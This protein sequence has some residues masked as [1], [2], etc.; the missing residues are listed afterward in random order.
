MTFTRPLGMIFPWAV[1]TISICPKQAHMMAM[2]KNAMID[3]VRILPMGDGGVSRISRAAGR[4]SRSMLTMFR[5]P[6]FPPVIPRLPDL[7]QAGK[8]TGS[9]FFIL[10]ACLVV[11]GLPFF[12]EPELLVSHDPGLRALPGD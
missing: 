10:P 8:G 9:S 4:N 1:V 11:I 6:I 12:H 5:S 3:Q 2:K 7:R